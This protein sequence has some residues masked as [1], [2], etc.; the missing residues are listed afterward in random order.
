MFK[1]AIT[2]N[3]GSGKSTVLGF[4]KK[5][6]YFVSSSDE[7]IKKIYDHQNYRAAVL[8]CLNIKNSDFKNEILKKIKDP[9]FNTKLK[10]KLYPIMNRL[11]NN[12][13]HSHHTKKNYFLK[14][15]YCLKKSWK[16]IMI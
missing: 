15:H 10:R 9:T 13:I 1:V 3:I 14:C 5:N 6:K 12:S 4:F 16:K 11:R 8:K 2:G 7:I